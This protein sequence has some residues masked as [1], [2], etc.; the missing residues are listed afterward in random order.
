[1]SRK[2]K[3]GRLHD[4]FLTY[5]YPFPFCA[6]CAFLRL[7]KPPVIEASD[8][9]DKILGTILGSCDI[10]TKGKM[11]SCSVLLYHQVRG[12]AFG[13]THLFKPQK[14]AKGAKRG[15][16]RDGKLVW[17]TIKKACREPARALQIFLST[18]P[19]TGKRNGMTA[20]RSD[21]F[22]L[23]SPHERRLSCVIILNVERSVFSINRLTSNA[24][25][26]TAW[27]V[28]VKTVQ[29]STFDVQR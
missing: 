20:K 9:K 5:S 28:K 19:P 12:A 23:L 26:P 16:C 11:S 10:N 21:P 7:T 24:V 29:Y 22:M 2:T 15:C 8:P 18:I 27:L 1:M 13:R 3:T 17:R 6:F 14:N 4:P 25:T